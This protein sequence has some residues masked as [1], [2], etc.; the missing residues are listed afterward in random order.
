MGGSTVAKV[1]E[2]IPNLTNLFTSIQHE[3]D[4]RLDVQ[5]EYRVPVELNREKSDDIIR[6]LKGFLDE[7]LRTDLERPFKTEE[8][9]EEPGVWAIEGAFIYGQLSLLMK[10]W[11]RELGPLLCSHAGNL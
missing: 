4:R 3:A 2:V 11:T 6:I 10:D 9:I 8:I 1:P 5:K 7:N